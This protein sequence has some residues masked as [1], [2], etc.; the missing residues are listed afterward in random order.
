MMR[1]LNQLAA[2]LFF[3]LVTYVQAIASTSDDL[4][5]TSPLSKIS[6]SLS[7]PVPVLVATIAVAITGLAMAFSQE[8]SGGIK[9]ICVATI[10]ISIA[11][12]ANAFIQKVFGASGAL[13]F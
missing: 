4:P 10:G 3:S 6:K 7:G 12:M 5:W 2:G 9:K 13:I 11:V 8:L 1:K